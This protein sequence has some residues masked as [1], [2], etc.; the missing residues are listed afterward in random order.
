MMMKDHDVP[1]ARIATK[2]IH[3]GQRPDESTG[4]VMPVISLATTYVQDSPGVHK[5]M[6]YSRAH[7]PTRYALERMVAQLEGSPI[8]EAEDVSCGGFAF[9][10]GMSAM[11]AALDLLDAGSRIVTMD[12]L[13][14]GSTRLL[15]QVRRRTQDLD[16]ERVDMSD[17]AKFEAVDTGDDCFNVMRVIVLSVDDDDVFRASRNDKLAVHE[18]TAIAGPQPAVARE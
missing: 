12:D 9:A 18:N 6:D 7:N 2:V 17:L 11:A 15:D 1:N 5:G 4:A 14:G 13:Y 8:S 10:S 3:A 16:I